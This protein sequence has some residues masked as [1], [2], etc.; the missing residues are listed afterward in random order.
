VEEKIVEVLKELFRSKR[1]E[2]TVEFESVCDGYD[3]PIVRVWIDN[4]LVQERW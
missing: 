3:R 1:L 2:I 4:E